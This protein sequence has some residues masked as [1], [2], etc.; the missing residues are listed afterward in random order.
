MVYKE[1]FS[2]TLLEGPHGEKIRPLAKSLLGT[3]ACSPRAFV[4]I[5][6]CQPHEIS[7]EVDTFSIELLDEP[8]TLN[9]VL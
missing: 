3:E 9:S 8:L 2:L 7:L 6:F 1:N 4:E 5:K